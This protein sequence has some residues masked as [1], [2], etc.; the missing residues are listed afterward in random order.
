MAYRNVKHYRHTVHL[1]L[2]SI[3]PISTNPKKARTT[4]YKWLANQMGMDYYKC[5]VKWFTRDQCRQAI[6]ILKAKHIQLY[7]K[8]L[9]WERA[10]QRMEE[11]KLKEMEELVKEV[12]GSYWNYRWLK[13]I[14]EFPEY[15]EDGNLTGN[16]EQEAY[17]EL[18]EVYYDNDEK[19]FMWTE[20]C[21]NLLV[22]NAV[23]LMELVKRTLDAAKKPV[24]LL[25]KGQDE[26]DTDKITELDEYIDGMEELD[27]WLVNKQD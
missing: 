15:D 3:W 12:S 17:Y 24:L 9:F 18:H 1:Y 13:I 27:K 6:R 4:M 26:D 19:P 11:E 20:G 5:H 8:D 16:N 2:D 10:K 14:Q 23:D 22:E 21:T 7:G 25:T